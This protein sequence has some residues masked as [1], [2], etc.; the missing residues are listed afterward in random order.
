MKKNKGRINVLKKILVIA[1]VISLL[2]NHIMIL[3]E[4]SNIA[5]ATEVEWQSDFTSNVRTED[6][7]QI[8]PE[9]EGETDTSENTT[10]NEEQPVEELPGEEISEENTAEVSEENVVE[11]EENQTSEEIVS[12]EEKN[13]VDLNTT[14]PEETQPELSEEEL[15]ALQE[16]TAN[17]GLQIN[18]LI[19]YDNESGKGTLVDL[20]FKFD[21]D[22]KDFDVD[23][24]ELDFTLP[25][26]SDVLPTIY[27]VE[28]ISDNMEIVQD[29]EAKRIHLTINEV[30]NHYEEELRMTLIYSEETFSGTE[31]KINGGVKVNVQ[32]YQVLGEFNET[33]EAKETSEP[34]AN[35]SLNTDT[36]SRYKGYLY[37]NNLL[38]NKKDIAYTTTNVVDVKDANF[39]D[40]IIV[41]NNI[42]KFVSDTR[43]EIDLINQVSYKTSS[44]SVD[45]FDSILGSGGYI[46][47]YN[48][49]GEKLGEI[50]KSSEIVN[51][52]YV[53]NYSTDV[54]RVIF[55]IINAESNKTLN[56]KND[57]VLKGTDDFSREY[58]SSFKSIKFS[59]VNKI[60][61][62]V[63]D[64]EIIVQQIQSESSMNLEETESKMTL[65]LD[66]TD[67]I[68]T[69]QNEV[70][71]SV[72]LKT[73][74]ERYDLFRN[75]TISIELPSAV[76]NVEIKNVNLMYKNGLSL[77]SWNVVQNEMGTNTIQVALEGTQA[78]YAPGTLIEGTTVLITANLDL[79]KITANGKSSVKLRYTNEAGNNIS[80][81]VAGKAS[82]DVEV[83]YVSRSGILKEA[84]LEN[85]N[86]AN[87]VL[88][89]YEDET[90][91]GAIE[92]NNTGKTAKVSTVVMNNYANE[93][94]NVQIVGKIPYIG[95]T[96][97][98]VDLNT[99]F[100]TTLAGPVTLNGLVGKVYYS[101][102]ENP[103][104]DSGNWQENITDFSQ[105]K[106][107]KVVVENPTMKV[108]EKIEISYNLNIPENVG[109]NASAYNLITT[110]YNLN[111]EQVEDYSIIGIESEERDI[112]LVDCQAIEETESLAIGIQATKGPNIIEDGEEI[113]ERQ[114]VKYNVIIQNTSN[115]PI[116]NIRIKANAENANTYYWH[117]FEM[118]NSTDGQMITAGEMKEDTD[119]S[120]P[121]E[122]TIIDTLQP[123]ESTNFS[124]QVI[125]KDVDEI[126]SNGL[127]GKV[128]VSADGIEEK[129]YN[130]VK[131]T[132]RRG[133]IE[134]SIKRSG[135]ENIEDMKIWSNGAY[136][137]E[138]SVKNLTNEVLENVPVSIFLSES[139][140]ANEFTKNELIDVTL[141]GIEKVSNGTIVTVQI[142]KIDVGETFSFELTTY[143]KSIE[144]I[145]QATTNS[146][147]Y[148][149]AVIDNTTYISNNYEREISQSETKINTSFTSNI[150][151]NSKVNDGDKVTY[152]ITAEN[153]GLVGE[154][155]TIYD[156]LPYG[157]LVD[158]A[159]A[160]LNNG[161]TRALEADSD[162][163]IVDTD[164]VAPLE[165]YTI[166]IEGTIN[167]DDLRT[168]QT[169]IVNNFKLGVEDS[170]NEDIIF[171]I[172]NIRDAQDENDVNDQDDSQI[173]GQEDG[174]IDYD[175]KYNNSDN[176]TNTDENDDL[177]N[178]SE[179][180]DNN[181]ESKNDT[182]NITDNDENQDVSNA[183]TNISQN[184]EQNNNANRLSNSENTDDNNTNAQ[185]T[186]DVTIEMTS[187]K[188][189]VYS[190][191]GKAWLDKDEN[192][193]YKD[194]ELL[195]NVETFLYKV[196]S[197]NIASIS[198][199]NLV[200]TTTTDENGEYNF[201]NLSNGKYVV[202]FNYDNTRYTI[203][204]YQSN[205]ERDSKTS[206]VVAKELKLNNDQKYYAVSDILEI[207]D[208]SVIDVN[209]GLNENKSFDMKVDTYISEV[210]VK[211]QNGTETFSFSEEDKPAKIEIAAK[212]IEGSVVTATY[213]IK[214]T[215]NSTQA[216]YVNQ[217]SFK[218]PYGFDIV[219]S[220]NWELGEDGKLYNTSLRK[221]LLESGES[222]EFVITL[223]KTMTGDTTGTY[224]A[225]AQILNST[226]DLQ[227][228]DSNL[229]NDTSNMDLLITI[230]TGAV[231]YVLVILIILIL[232]IIAIVLVNKILKNKDTKRIRLINKIIIIVAIA[233][234]II[235]CLVIKIYATSGINVFDEVG[236][237]Q[238]NDLANGWT[239]D[240]YLN[241]SRSSLVGQEWRMGG[242]KYSTNQ[243]VEPSNSSSDA[244]G[245]QRINSVV[246]INGS[247]YYRN[248][249]SEMTDSYAVYF[250]SIGKWLENH[251]SSNAYHVISVILLKDSYAKE[252]SAFSTI[253]GHSM[254]AANTEQNN[255][256]TGVEEAK[257]QASKDM[258]NF[259]K[260][261]NIAK[262][263]TGN[264]GT[265]EY[266]SSVK[267]YGP[268][269]VDIPTGATK[270]ELKYTVNGG[271]E[272]T[273]SSII[274]NGSTTTFSTSTDQKE[275]YIPKSVFD[276]LDSDDVVKIKCIAYRNSIK[277]K[278]T[279]CIGGGQNRVILRG[280]D[281][282]TSSN[283]QYDV[284]LTKPY[285]VQVNKYL[286]QI[287]NE[288][289][290]GRKD[291][292]SKTYYAEKGDTVVFRIDVK[293]TLSGT[294]LKDIEITD[295][296]GD[297]LTFKDF[298]S[299]NGNYITDG[300]SG[301]ITR[302]GNKF[303]ISQVSGGNTTSIFVRCT[304]TKE[305][306]TNNE[307][308][309]N[310]AYVSSMKDEENYK[311]YSKNSYDADYKIDDGYE[312]EPSS[313]VRSEDSLKTKKYSISVNKYINKINTT[314]YSSRASGSKPTIY[315]EYQD[316]VEYTIVIKNT[317]VQEQYG[318]FKTISLTDELNNDSITVLSFTG[319]NG[320]SGNSST[321]GNKTTYNFT[322]NNGNG[323]APG[324]T[325]TLK[326]TLQ[327]TGLRQTPIVSSNKVTITSLKNRNNI[328]LIN[329]PLTNSIT[330]SSDQFTIKGYNYGVGKVITNIT[331]K[332]GKNVGRK[333]YGE[334]GDLVNYTITITNKGTDV[335]YGTITNIV[336]RDD[337]NSA[338]L[339]YVSHND[340]EWTRNGNVYT[341]K[342]G[343]LAYGKSATL[344]IRM[345]VK[346]FSINSI[347]ITNTATIT[348]A[349]NI[350]G[351]DVL[352]AANPVTSSVTFKLDEYHVE[353]YKYT[354]LSASQNFGDS[355]K[356]LS[357]QDKYNNPIEVEKYES[358]QY[359]IRLKNTAERTV[360][361]NPELKD[362]LEDGIQYSSMISAKV[363][364][365]D[366]RNNIEI[367]PNGQITTFRYNGTLSP[368]QELVIVV[369]TNITKSN[370]YLLNLTNK[371]EIQKVMNRNELD[372]I[373][374]NVTN[375]DVDT[376]EEYVRLKNLVLSGKVW[377]DTNRDGKMDDNE[378][379]LSG[380]EVILHDDTNKKVAT[381]FTDAQGNYLFG[382]TNGKNA[383]GTDSNKKMVEGGDNSG[384]IIKAT[385]R[386]DTTGNYNENS[387]YIN[388]YVEFYY[389]GVRYT[390]TVYAGNDGMQNINK[391]DNS[392]T[393][394]YMT[395]SNAYEYSDV[396]DEFNN[397]LE[398]IEYNKGINGTVEN[399]NNTQNITYT[400][401]GH[402]STLDLTENSGMSAYSFIMQN[403]PHNGNIQDGKN[404]N[405]L[406]FSE[407]G[408][409]EYLKYINLGLQTRDFDI[410]IDQDVYSLK[411]TVNGTEMTY[412]LDQGNKSNS[413]YGGE[414]V[415]G[416]EQN[417]INYQ[418]KLYASDYY[419]KHTQYT[420]QDVV[421]Y[422]VNTELNT[423]ITYKMT[424]TNHDVQDDNNVYTKV[425]EV[426]DYY[427]QDFIKY[428]PNSNTKTIK[429][430][431]EDG[432]LQD[433]V[434]NNVE[435][436]YEFID[437]NNQKIT[438]EVTLSNNP[439]YPEHAKVD[440]GTN[441]RGEAKYDVVYLSG[442]DNI[443]LSEG[444]SFD[445]Y[446]K[447]VVDT[448]DGTTATNQFLGDKNNIVEINAYSTYYA[449]DNR[450]AGYVDTNSNPGN[451]GLQTD[452]N[453]PNGTENAN[454]ED[455]SEYE[456]DAYKTGVTLSILE[457]GDSDNP[458]PDDPEDT[459]NEGTL[460]RV[461]KGSVWDD[462]RSTTSGQ[463]G[464]TQY[465]GNGIKNI[466]VDS[467][468]AEA[469]SNQKVDEHDNLLLDESTDQPAEGIKV[470]LVEIVNVPKNGEN[471]IYE[472]S[473]KT[474]DD[475]IMTT[476]TSEDGSYTLESFIP[477]EYI[478]RFDYGE[479]VEDVVYNGQEYKST[480]YYN[481]DDKI[482]EEPDSGDKVL[483]ALEEEN[484]SDARDDEIR[485]L[486]VIRYSET[487]N[488]RKT[489]EAQKNL[490]EEYSEEFMESTNM[491]ANTEIFPIRAEKT[492]YDIKEYT[493]DQYEAGVNSDL[494]Y[495]VENIDFGVEYR[496]E[497]N[498]S[499]EE[500]ISEIKLT[501]SDGNILA[502]INFDNVYEE[503]DGVQSGRIIGTTINTETSVGYENL[504]YLPTVDDVKGLAYLNVDEDI[505][506]GCTVDITYVFSVNNDS[507]VDRISQNLYKLRYKVDATG[508][509]Q[510]FDDEYT[511]AGTA[512]NELYSKYFKTDG[513][514][515]RT[516]EKTTYDGTNGYYGKY[517]GETYYSGNVGSNDIVAE[518]KVNKILDYVDNN[519]TMQ[520]DKNQTE[521]RYWRTMANEELLDQG[522]VAP[523]IF[524]VIQET[525]KQDGET[526]VQGIK[527]L[528]DEDDVT[529]D[530]DTRHNLA[531]SVDDRISENDSN[532]LN[533]ALSIFL[534]PHVSD[535][536]KSAGSVY[537][538]ASK[539][540]SGESDTED[541]VYDNSAEIIEY[542]S[543]TGRVTKLSTT[544]GNLNMNSNPEYEDD[545]DFTERITLAPPTGLE[546]AEYY[547]SI[548]RDQ[549]VMVAIVIAVV[550]V[551]IILK[552]SLKNVTFKKFYK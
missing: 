297:G 523:G 359:T 74:E 116:N 229:D 3:G 301:T 125:V 366:V 251:K 310:R 439:I 363:G 289:I 186:E 166:I 276:G 341:Y 486:E 412:Y 308:L 468:I 129:E 176:N 500:F 226:N 203:T 318:N 313:V 187:N 512:R 191:S 543:V 368:N 134:L 122:E 489:E 450:P 433:K 48:V 207:N 179:D 403:Q 513:A 210:S 236:V 464:D 326:L 351:K 364:N 530:V 526:Q 395:D 225:E 114:I 534:K 174:T 361:Y 133:K 144:N 168:N 284:E 42:D 296:F 232:A 545:S 374:N 123:G 502:D 535:F 86:D 409:T 434:I 470:N 185:D 169:T 73:N 80:Y 58:I 14:V 68:T 292:K 376:G 253:M 435:A 299:A 367:V 17:T 482:T 252:A 161:E 98:G 319:N 371:I 527:Q 382:E 159:Y 298:K 24:V 148:A 539:V 346:V 335:S 128:L 446:I 540:V 243:C 484:K 400:K 507:E 220:I 28:E 474:W 286:T 508:Y 50:N 333:D 224:T 77:S 282:E 339:E 31:V 101:T 121:Y 92:A 328:E 477:G 90:V 369:E 360:L 442:F 62:N 44:V 63:N 463:G 277:A 291:D 323:L 383:D 281:S 491:N 255:Y 143:A 471:R 396:R 242:N 12:E 167:A 406:F 131:N 234:I 132:I 353:L 262:T 9:E 267:G 352:G 214:V 211:N 10:N 473:I 469:A 483:S 460:E 204:N 411:T 27:K 455:Y 218:V 33:Q 208:T 493:F 405:M 263:G 266:N 542:T 347:D 525:I 249:S 135:T 246:D 157:I 160:I 202:I 497:V 163:V 520:Q 300:T 1:F 287:Y 546:K 177:I 241:Y 256:T 36:S 475:S 490:P 21:I 53:F 270:V 494:R 304:V 217:I 151:N 509:E 357:K 498:V 420:N 506:Q 103:D 423:E 150:P 221:T 342:G 488:N 524:K 302:S 23:S 91:V 230:K 75:P 416:G 99:T 306:S 544:V 280:K 233:L 492:T 422:K 61:K 330:E 137:L 30:V 465:R 521:N 348:Q 278:I 182:E 440:L 479:S 329:V 205:G 120:H 293:N 529:Y 43:G 18:K 505:L 213:N 315:G 504:Q 312:L 379:K 193:L 432:Y 551:V 283:V 258:L 394:A 294:T 94:G 413:P 181:N 421:D 47:I 430:M 344:T 447:F 516:A 87:D 510:Y 102:E 487:V 454:I 22:T 503:T 156:Q 426:V 456:N 515:Y 478:V 49:L 285:G 419:Y 305:V 427:S 93:I 69:E 89:T 317:G 254:S 480:T 173:S 199:S 354:N 11:N 549:I 321:N 162:R 336:L 378:G 100:N 536:T 349:Q 438:G 2:A 259:T 248:S 337:F 511:A 436:W 316:I 34:L 437:S 459:D 461:I 127:Y 4:F 66:K 448:E 537:M 97:D 79:N 496:P 95:N 227:I 250:A 155:V 481:I 472:E 105:I 16:I 275:F 113:N 295:D 141:L 138:T 499:I 290:S 107:F 417:P 200:S 130:S 209:I 154:Y 158:N 222:E 170:E 322:Y 67:F 451:L 149:S 112:E 52:R 184:N 518:L 118:E 380:I 180:S 140:E 115:E 391:A 404:I 85:F 110:Y 431:G 386:D 375:Y 119:G 25:N 358:V 370:M 88:V 46:E 307:T 235:L 388:Y 72:T 7:G 372:I 189:P 195:S 402:I 32:G 190:I 541:M 418:F 332:N 528:L 237:I 109:Y 178:N 385:N 201:D 387:R 441:D 415:T 145:M 38:E 338:Q 197:E 65:E 84:K 522:L 425:R 39:I 15:Q 152:T 325:T 104:K 393:T 532:N 408:E 501:T 5:L 57:K 424:I 124:Y 64:N 212:Y 216:G 355:R 495:K 397:N 215:N 314:N 384:R 365:T 19:K 35:Y 26:I 76:Q 414:Y 261:G 257:N 172:D 60:A 309:T 550:I 192:G 70:T 443:N 452:A 6:D 389:N 183:E 449:D 188:I 548:A 457:D 273:I 381:T 458:D 165:K 260:G 206:S 331:D 476:R 268:I 20:T 136:Y 288:S 445:I 485:R 59:S 219:S 45:E 265:I 272:K 194:E 198:D 244:E 345:K 303:T 238:A 8:N 78:E 466:G 377:V 228:V 245:G 531:V 55:R 429:V 373:H 340:S 444:D 453:N 56:I 82:E 81:E 311:F 117:T 271:S 324:A 279:M 392:I 142:P 223:V 399:G 171:Y 274:V 96:K 146:N 240:D 552:R 538:V 362:T 350:R 37:A 147:A 547:L 164:Y 356:D 533:K 51:N 126:N 407:E 13:E 71:F 108:G 40:E 239:L 343:E 83:N 29:D 247:K 269:C 175:D 410:S 519:M 139:L 196:D 153:V 398:T 514:T 106:S 467:K 231:Y 517:L 462:A 390:S 320:W 327:I 428:D 111:D 264:I 401:D 54:D 334:T 41:E